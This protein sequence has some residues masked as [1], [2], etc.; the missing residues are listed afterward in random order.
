MAR[1]VTQRLYAAL[2]LDMHPSGPA[3]AVDF[4]IT[5]QKHYEALHSV[6]RGGEVTVD[7]LDAVLGDGPAITKLAQSCPANR[8]KDIVFVTPYDML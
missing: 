3:C 4:G 6:V 7:Q 1:P 8:H 2:M 5:S